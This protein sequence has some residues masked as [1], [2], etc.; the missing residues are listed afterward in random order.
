MKK[1]CSKGCPP[2]KVHKCGRRSR[3]CHSHHLLR[4]AC[5]MWSFFRQFSSCLFTFLYIGDAHATELRNASGQGKKK[6]RREHPV[7]PPVQGVLPGYF[8]LGTPSPYI[9]CILCLLQ[10]RSPGFDP[11]VGKI[12]WR[13]K[14]QPTPV[15]L[16]GKSHG[17]LQSM[18]SESRTRLSDFTFTF[19][20]PSKHFMTLWTEI[21]LL[22]DEKHLLN[23][24][25]T[26]SGNHRAIMSGFHQLNAILIT[27]WMMNGWV[28]RCPG[29]K[30]KHSWIKQA[31]GFVGDNG[32]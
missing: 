3:C 18:G 24:H 16:P 25:P 13:R 19:H 15:L 17:R 30:G 26:V 23:Q 1:T 4:G 29:S 20:F 21:P 2:I 12:P 7:K 8:F 10:C 31:E 9:G 6:K 22:K 14:W 32:D 5:T 28:Q 11:W 27:H